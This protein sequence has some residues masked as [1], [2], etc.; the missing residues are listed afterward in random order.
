MGDVK[1]QKLNMIYSTK[2]NKNTNEDPKTSSV[3]ENLMLLPDNVFWEILQTAAANKGILPEDAG[4][5]SDDYCFWPKW[6]PSSIYDTG[7][8][9]YVEPDVFFRFGNIDVIVEAKYSDNHGQYREEWEREFKAYLNEFENDKKKVVLLAVGGNRTFELESEI[10]IGRRKCPVVKYSW[11]KLLNAVLDYE[12]QGLSSIDDEN[13]SS[14][15]R[16]IRNIEF[17]FQN[18]GIIKIKDKVELKGL[19][20]LYALGQVFQSAI[21]RETKYYA[22]SYCKEEV[23]RLHY[24]CQFEVKPKDGRKKSI[25]LSIALWINGQE[26]IAIEARK[27]EKWAGKLCKLIENDKKFS[28]KYAEK[29]QW[30]NNCYY[31]DAKEKFY[32]EFSEAETFDAQVAIVSKLIDDVCLFYI[33]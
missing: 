10:K 16:I 32:K 9:N 6:N 4:I 14:M 25:K 11:V 24:G 3:F 13:Q 1:E 23:N 2:H 27:F 19:R 8:C 15:K 31:F 18:I 5:L 30:E 17:S 7:N 12:E 21:S 28:S 22:L 26:V 29:P 20:N 33:K